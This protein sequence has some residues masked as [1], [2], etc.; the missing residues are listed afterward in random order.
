MRL[1]KGFQPIMHRSKVGKAQLPN[2]RVNCF[3]LLPH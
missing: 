3:D 2:Y 1:G